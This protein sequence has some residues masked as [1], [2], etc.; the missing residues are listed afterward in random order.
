MKRLYIT[1]GVGGWVE[2]EIQLHTDEYTPEQVIE[3]LKSGKILTSINAPAPL[4]VLKDDGFEEI[5]EIIDSTLEGDN[6]F[7]FELHR[8]WDE[9]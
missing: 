1:Y 9:H 2:Q 8:S 5:G 3:M 6:F 4:V 7:D